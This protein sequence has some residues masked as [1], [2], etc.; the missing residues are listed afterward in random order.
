MTLTPHRFVVEDR[1]YSTPCHVWTRALNS[2]GYALV[3]DGDRVRCAHVVI[4]EEANGPTPDGHELDHLCRVRAC[5]NEAHLEPVTSAENSRRGAATKLTPAD[6][7]E[8]RAGRAA[9]VSNIELADRFGVSASWV[10]RIITGR[11]VNRYGVAR[12]WA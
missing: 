4:W 12:A 5:V 7:E 9:G 3:R 11:T 10:S 6:I 1:G 8:I 2:S